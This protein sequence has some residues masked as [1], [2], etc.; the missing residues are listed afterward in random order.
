VDFIISLI[1][2]RSLQ[3]YLAAVRK[4][5]QSFDLKSETKTRDEAPL[6]FRISRGFPPAARQPK[7][8]PAVPG[9][10]RVQLKRSA[11]GGCREATAD[12]RRLPTT[13][14]NCWRLRNCWSGRRTVCP[15]GC[16]ARLRHL[17][18]SKKAAISD[19]PTR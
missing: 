19:A 16:D 3:N 15:Y 13:P 5:N 11:A 4:Q 9:V 1:Y 7:K 8:A 18:L 12:S 17:G 10:F 2:H 14:R 6:P